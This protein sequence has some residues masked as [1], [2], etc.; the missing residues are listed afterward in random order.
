MKCSQG[1]TYSN[2]IVGTTTFLLGIFLFYRL[3]VLSSLSEEYSNKKIEIRN[4]YNGTGDLTIKSLT[5]IRIQ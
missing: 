2:C 1:I 3:F 4:F 5:I